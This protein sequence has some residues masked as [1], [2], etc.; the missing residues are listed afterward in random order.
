MTDTAKLIEKHR[1][2]L[3]MELLEL[4]ESAEK[5]FANYPDYEVFMKGYKFAKK[6]HQGQ[7]RD[8]SEV[9][10]IVHP[11]RIAI[12]LYDDFNITDRV[13][14]L[15]A[16]FHDLIEDSEIE[17][18][19]IAA[20][21]GTKVGEYT[22]EMTRERSDQETPAEKHASKERMFKEFE[23]KNFALR[24][25]KVLDV[26]DSMLG[27]RFINPASKLAGKFPRWLKQYQ[28]VTRPLAQTLGPKYTDL[29]DFL[30]NEMVELGHKPAKTNNFIK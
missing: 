1:R 6:G 18:G 15:T 2:L 17:E 19:D 10:Y 7:T 26:Y 16:L 25:L 5:L 21:F 14:L 29:L 23:S 3:A 30:Y 11:L 22:Q 12:Y 13:T 4:E 8:G 9:P 27:W 28:E 20:K 24:Q